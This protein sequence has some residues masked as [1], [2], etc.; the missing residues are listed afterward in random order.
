MEKVGAVNRYTPY[1]A[2]GPA[3]WTINL[4]N[5]TTP[6]MHFFDGREFSSSCYRIGSFNRPSLV[7]TH[8]H[9]RP[10]REEFDKLDQDVKRHVLNGG[11][12]CVEIE[13]AK[14]LPDDPVQVDW[15][16]EQFQIWCAGYYGCRLGSQPECG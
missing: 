2:Q 3:V 13:K 9:Y 11:L 10:T 14:Q 6:F 8:A 4:A 12:L 5:G 16:Y 15:Q 1:K 7:I